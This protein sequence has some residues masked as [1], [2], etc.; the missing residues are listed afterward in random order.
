MG[1]FKQATT[2]RLTLKTDANYWVDVTTDLTYGD[3][4]KFAT[5]DGAQVDFGAQ[6]DVFLQTV[7]KAWNLDDDQGVVLDITP[8]NIDRLEKDD[9]LYIINE[10]GGLVEDDTSKKDS[11]QP[12]SVASV[13]TP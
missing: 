6:A 13:E 2:K 3:I 7:I 10:A 9:V 12:S 8:E 11:P 4:K 5:Q 1:Y